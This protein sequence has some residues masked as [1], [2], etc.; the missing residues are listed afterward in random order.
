MRI[1]IA[2]AAVAIALAAAAPAHAQLGFRLGAG[3]SWP[4][5]DI[6]G[7]VD[8][9][10]N[11]LAG[12]ALGMPLIPIGLRA[13]LLYNH[14]VDPDGGAFRTFSLSG[15]G[16]LRM[17]MGPLSPYL[18]GGLGFYNSVFTDHDDSASN[19]FGANIGAGAQL[20]LFGFGGFVEARLHHLFNEGAAVR[21]VPVTLGVIF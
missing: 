12:V 19:N 15:N 1:R 14:L 18:I 16:V 20:T 13:D 9:G 4:S 21:F 6:S 17:P 11:V 5:G 3:P 2:A 10:F 7:H 8:P